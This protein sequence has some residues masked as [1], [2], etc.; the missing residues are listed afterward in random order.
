MKFH[1]SITKDN[2]ERLA[3]I[4]IKNGIKREKRVG[5]SMVRGYSEIIVQGFDIIQGY[6]K[7]SGFLEVLSSANNLD[8]IK[9]VLRKNDYS[10]KEDWGKLIRVYKM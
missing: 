9:K 1:N 5:S 4:L 2:A 7:E 8:E 3:K 10:Y 6:P